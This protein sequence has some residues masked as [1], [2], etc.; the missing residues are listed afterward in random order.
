YGQTFVGCSNYPTCKYIKSDGSAPRRFFR[1][2]GSYA[3]K[4]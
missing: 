1:R 3:K 4:S 2:K